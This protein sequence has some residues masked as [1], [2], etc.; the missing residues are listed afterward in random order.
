MSHRYKNNFHAIRKTL[1]M[2][3]DFI[4]VV[5]LLNSEDFAA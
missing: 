5:V 1:L 2:R 3:L 4:I